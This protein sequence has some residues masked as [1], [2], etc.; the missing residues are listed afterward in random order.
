MIATELRFIA[1]DLCWAW[2]QTVHPLQREPDGSIKRQQ[3]PV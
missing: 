1:I 3:L 2:G